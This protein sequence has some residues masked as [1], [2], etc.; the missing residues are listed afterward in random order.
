MGAVS[1]FFEELQGSRVENGTHAVYAS[2]LTTV[3]K[4]SFVVAAIFRSDIP[5]SCNAWNF[6]TSTSTRGLPSTFP[7]L[8]ARCK[9]ALVRSD[10]R[11]RSCLANV[12]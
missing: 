10:M 3:D 5:P 9:P 8:L 7:A 2:D 4:L 1:L 11:S 6:F 12:A